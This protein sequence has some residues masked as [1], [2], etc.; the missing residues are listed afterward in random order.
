LR[1]AAAGTVE[2]PYHYSVVFG[3]SVKR[4]ANRLAAPALFRDGAP[5]ADAEH[6]LVDKNKGER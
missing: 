6:K 1:G 2:R 4:R 3:K 5:C